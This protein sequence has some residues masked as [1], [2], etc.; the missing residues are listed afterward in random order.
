M[1]DPRP[2]SLH[3]DEKIER[4]RAILTE[5]SDV[6]ATPCEV[7]LILDQVAR[8]T[9]RAFTGWVTVD[10]ADCAGEFHRVA[11]CHPD[12]YRADRLRQANP[13]QG[14][15]GRRRGHA[16]SPLAMVVPLIARETR[17]GTFCVGAL[18]AN[19]PYQ[20]E[21]F[22]LAVEIG[23]RCT[24]VIDN[25]RL[26]ATE[27]HSIAQAQDALALRDQ[28]LSIAAHELKT[29]LTSMLGM[30]QIAERILAH[31]ETPDR[32]RLLRYLAIIT[33]QG[34]KLAK[35]V[36][37]VLDLAR[38]E[39]DRLVLDREAT[40]VTALVESVV[41]RFRAAD[42]F[43]PIDIHAPGPISAYVDPLRLEQALT[44]LVDNAF[45]YSPAGS[46]V[47]VKLETTPSALTIAVIDHGIGIP[48]ERREHIFE[49][50]YQAHPES[51]RSGLGLGLFLSRHIVEQLGGTL[52]VGFP[53]AGGTRFLIR[54]PSSL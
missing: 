28:F 32:E 48:P 50:F 27:R 20:D 21:D 33:D 6:L 19:Q 12:P 30:S 23:R 13:N 15:D 43:H 39:G 8:V 9:A 45:K 38:W 25:A 10:V 2:T 17:V 44:N 5:V 34:R 54:L 22:A 1:E 4:R 35:L 3:D 7:P 42:D 18:A 46:P 49:R 36:D 52:T 37:Q 24:L 51:Y 29:P 16:G 53:E 11:V 31:H 47:E 40:D 41:E 26:V 14:D